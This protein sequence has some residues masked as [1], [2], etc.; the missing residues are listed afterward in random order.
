MKI[1]FVR[2]GGGGVGKILLIFG[3]DASCG[4]KEIQLRLSLHDS[5]HVDRLPRLP[6]HGL[7]QSG[8]FI[9]IRLQ[10]QHTKK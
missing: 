6:A 8:H 9:Q 1:P 4:Q 7:I 2:S 5:L 3:S 10:I